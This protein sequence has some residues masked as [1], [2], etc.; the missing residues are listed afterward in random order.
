MY[1]TSTAHICRYA[2]ITNTDAYPVIEGL[3]FIFF[4]HVFARAKVKHS[5][6]TNNFSLSKKNRPEFDPEISGA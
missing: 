3:Y 1:M 6:L 4:T 2:E 5:N